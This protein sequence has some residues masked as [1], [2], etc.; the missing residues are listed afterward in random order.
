M[1]KF[2]FSFTFVFG[3]LLVAFT[4]KGFATSDV[5]TLTKDQALEETK[6]FYLE[7]RQDKL[8][9]LAD[10]PKDSSEDD[11]ISAIDEYVENNPA[12][13]GSENLDLTALF[14]ELSLTTASANAT[15]NL[16]DYINEQKAVNP[17]SVFEFNDGVA[18]TIVHVDETGQL[19]VTSAASSRSLPTLKGDVSTM[20]TWKGASGS[21]N[22]YLY[23]GNNTKLMRLW[24]KANF[25][26]NGSDVKVNT[27]EGDHEKFTGGSNL[28]VTM[29]AKGKGRIVYEGSY[30]YAEV[31]T[32]AYISSS[33]PYK[34]G[35]LLISSGTF[36]T[37]TGS[38][39]GGSIYGGNIKI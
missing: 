34:F 9:L 28:K 16:T 36:E 18:T 17:D 2:L 23:G 1:K 8:N 30:K 38:T 10:L 5:S 37:Y 13:K 29:H 14:P 32:R 20:A 22:L 15:V 19:T 35:S 4:A 3:L 31:Y 6:A 25:Q 24:V 21:N 27:G 7:S 39:V 26:Y 11:V 33:I 12:P